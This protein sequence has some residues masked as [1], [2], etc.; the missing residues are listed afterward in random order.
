MI[1]ELTLLSCLL[2]KNYYNKYYQY[3]DI[4]SLKDICKEVFY[5]YQALEELQEKTD[6]S[7]S[8][9]DLQ[10]Y[11]FVRYPQAEKPLYEG[12]FRT[13]QE[14]LLSEGLPEVLLEEIKR[15]KVALKLSE[16]AFQ[17]SQGT[18][19]QES[20]T[21]FY[22]QLLSHKED[23]SN[24]NGHDIDLESV[25]ERAYTHSGLRWRLQFLNKSLGSL[26]PGDFGFMI[27]R[28]ETGGTA[29]VASEVAYM[30]PQTDKPIVWI[31]NEESN[32]KVILRVWQAYFGCTREQLLSNPKRYKEVF[33]S[34]VGDRFK[35]FGIEYSNKASIESIIDR[36]SPALVVY[37]QLD[38]I[39]GFAADR[40]DLMLGNIYKWVRENAKK[41]H[42]AFGVTQA[43]GT[44]E[45]VRYLTMQHVAES[46]TS[47]AATADFIF[48]MGMVHD[49]ELEN[50]RYI[51]ISKNKLMGDSDSLPELR[52]GKGEVLINKSIMQFEDIITYK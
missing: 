11:F 43:D 7:P 41:G 13:L 16:T 28:P 45:G 25:L 15:R 1:P 26:R 46:K 4:K 23:H 33:Y 6:S 24:L 44:A 30:L 49:T 9:N 22:E 48:G 3:V 31:N 27:K 8:L 35:F 14:A 21:E 39:S 42:A 52:H 12:L 40:N 34:Q 2:D 17:Y 10:A 50:V 29:M 51:N 47:K 32:D 37:D 18:A 5:L 38:N 19:S 36:Y 20:L